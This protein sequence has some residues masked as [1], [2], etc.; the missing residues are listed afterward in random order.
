ME[1]QY[2]YIIVSRWGIKSS[3]QQIIFRYDVVPHTG[4][5]RG[6]YARWLRRPRTTSERRQNQTH[7]AR[8]K[9]KKLPTTYDDINRHMEKNW[10]KFRNFHKEMGIDY[11]Q[12]LSTEFDKIFTKEAISAAIK[13][14]K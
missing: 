5:S 2:E 13:K 3:E 12:I 7:W 8:P 4:A 10:K 1:R 6:K 11:D 9:R 14:I